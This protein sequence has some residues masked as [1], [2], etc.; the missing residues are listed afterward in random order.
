[1]KIRS[2]RAF[3]LIELLVVITIIAILAAIIFSV[4]AQAK[5]AA[6]ATQSLSNLKQ[7]GLAWTLYNLDYDDTVMRVAVTHPDRVD[8]WWGSYDGTDLDPTGGLLYP[9]ARN[10]QIQADPTF[11][12]ILRGVLGQ[13]GYAYNYAYL[14]PSTYEPPT[15]EETPIPVNATQ[16]EAVSESVAFASSARMNSWSGPSP[17]LEGNTY[18]EAPSSEYPTLHGRNAD[19]ATVL[20]C[21]SHAKKTTPVLRQGEFG[22]GYQSEWFTPHTLGELV[23]PDHPLGSPGQDYFFMLSKPN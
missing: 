6:K 22:F 5:S 21:D 16:I 18:L 2:K 7:I 11:S 23:H 13:T 9:Y 14:S 3:T 19:R 10:H 8:Y 1:M 15:W 20:W 17:I 4:L 12:Q